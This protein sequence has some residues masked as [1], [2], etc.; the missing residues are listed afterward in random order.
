MSDFD[1]GIIRRKIADNETA[2]FNEVFDVAVRRRPFHRGCFYP[3]LLNGEAGAA[4]YSGA[5]DRSG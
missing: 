2:W 3:P 4:D 5:R 1:G